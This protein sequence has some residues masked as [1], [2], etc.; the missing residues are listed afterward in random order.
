MKKEQELRTKRSCRDHE[1]GDDGGDYN[2]DDDDNDTQPN[3]QRAPRGEATHWHGKCNL[4][5]KMKNR[6]RGGKSGVNRGDRDH[7]D[8]A[9]DGWTDRET[10]TLEEGKQSALL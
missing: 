3:K 4:L 6:R 2:D 8:I 7:G 1:L 10:S 9:I 5:C